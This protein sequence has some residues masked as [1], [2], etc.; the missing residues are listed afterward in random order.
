[1]S[2]CPVCVQ[3][4]RTLHRVDPVKA[5]SVDDPNIRYE[6][7]LTYL[8]EDLS[9]AYGVKYLL[10]IIDVFSRKAMIY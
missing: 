7:D 9:K 4:S 10:G 2:N 1:M 5:I 8:N 3:S 6:F